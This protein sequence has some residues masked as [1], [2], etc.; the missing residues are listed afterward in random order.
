MRE[1]H[2]FLKGCG[3]VFDWHPCCLNPFPT[4]AIWDLATLLEA[5]EMGIMVRKPD[6]EWCS[7][8]TRVKQLV[9]WQACV[10]SDRCCSLSLCGP[11]CSAQCQSRAAD[12]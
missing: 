10:R 1:L 9:Q 5:V 7:E 12:G 4:V 3:I 8:L 2:P 11:V 6:P